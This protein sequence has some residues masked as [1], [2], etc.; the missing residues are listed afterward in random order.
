[1][2]PKFRSIRTQIVVTLLIT[3]SIV[4]SVLG[5]FAYQRLKVLPEIILDQ[6]QEIASAR[7]NELGNEIEGLKNQ[8][9]MISL[10]NV[11]RSMDLP[12]IQELLLSMSMQ[13]RFRNFTFSD[14]QGQ[15]WAT[16]NEFIDISSQAQFNAIFTLEK[17]NYVSRPFFSP[18]ITDN[19][20]IITIS[21]AIKNDQ[22]QHIGLVNGVISTMFI[23]ELIKSITFLEKGYAWIV[24]DLGQVVAHPS[25]SITIRE[26]FSE[27]TR[28]DSSV[29]E[30]RELFSFTDA[31]VE[32]INVVAP[33]P[34]TNN[35]KLILSIGQQEAFSKVNSVIETISLYPILTL[36]ILFLILSILANRI[37]AP[38]IHLTDAFEPA[39]IGNMNIKANESI[40][41]EI[42]TAAKSF[43]E[44]LSK[45]K[46]LT[47]TDPITGLNNYFSF[48]NEM[49]L[50]T[51][52]RDSFKGSMYVMILS[53]DDFKRI[54]TIYGYDIGN[55][56]LKQLAANIQPFLRKGEMI[57]R[58][59]GDEMICSLFGLSEKDIRQRVETIV[60]L[61]RQTI[62]VVGIELQLNLRCGI[63][64]F[65]ETSTLLLTIRHASLA[66]H[67]AKLDV[68]NNIVVY[69][70]AIYL[71]FLQQQDLEE[72]VIHAIEHNEMY[73]L[74]QPIYSM[75]LQKICGYEALLRWNH[76]KYSIVP[77]IDVIKII[78]SKGLIHEVSKL[79]LSEVTL[80]L[81]KLNDV[82][83]K[84]SIA[85]NVSPLQLQNNIL[86][87]ALLETIKQSTINPHNL[88]LEI[89]EGATV[90][91]SDE[92]Q[93]ILR[94][95]KSLGVRIAID[96]FGSG[97][98]SLL[99]ITKLPI[100][101]IKI[102]REFIQK[103]EC[104][105][106]AKVLIV[107][108][109]SIASTLNLTVIAE[110]VET[111]QQADAL[112]ELNCDLIQG[113]FISKPKPL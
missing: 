13:S 73:L 72:A 38:I 23:D 21:Y 89:T 74:Y 44:M 90:L 24:D 49:N 100:D 94:R 63:A 20:P 93:T 88:V 79:I 81:N 2:R 26:H 9:E 82:D 50:L 91:D 84:L 47:Y 14:R 75:S 101:T 7:A 12:A 22:Q 32:F 60:T 28:L 110:G 97:Y 64:R 83:P 99:Y 31:G 8:I 52:S 1:M 43:N 96:D 104:D 77:I 54:N 34:N 30:S 59:F 39:K 109:L 78:E 68:A 41:N 55:E 107:S 57:A 69:S 3:M 105:D 42:G 113:Y 36:I 61:S 25:A 27:I 85:I 53:I 37:T 108:I 17:D 102:D 70:Q 112:R 48:L 65:D 80:K 58:Y 19:D 106:F 56:T 5:H 86:Y 4:F 51:S 71:D 33:I 16:Y 10:S 98:S 45:I 46:E 15:A 62:N 11:V 103:I 67:R 29:L 6:Y 66:K 87:D 95:L 18:F 35:W 76:P 92:K 111:S 40:R